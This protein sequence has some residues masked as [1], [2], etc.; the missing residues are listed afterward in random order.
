MSLADN[1]QRLNQRH[2][3]LHHR[4]HLSGEDGDVAGFDLFLALAEQLGFLAHADRVDALLAQLDLD[5]GVA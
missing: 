3:G 4:R 2:A 5:E 1:I